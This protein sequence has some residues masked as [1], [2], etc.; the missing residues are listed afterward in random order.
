MLVRWETGKG[1]KKAVNMSSD[2]FQMKEHFNIMKTTQEMA[3][4][5][6]GLCKDLNK[7]C[8]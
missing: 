5:I 8:D 1:T 6:Q 7:L 3:E 2:A 4:K